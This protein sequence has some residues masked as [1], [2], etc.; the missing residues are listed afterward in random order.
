MSMRYSI[1]LLSITLAACSHTS[2]QT[3]TQSSSNVV[4]MPATYAVAAKSST[5][6]QPLVSSEC[7]KG[8]DST[9]SYLEYLM[10]Q[11]Q[12]QAQSAL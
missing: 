2:A 7:A 4:V 3:S 12:A 10:E 8:F 1:L 5:P 9:I 11:R 6:H